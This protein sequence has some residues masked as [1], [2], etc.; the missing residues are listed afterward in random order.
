MAATFLS[1]NVSVQAIIA[2][3]ES[4][5]TAL[6][7]SRV[8]SPVPIFAMSPIESSRRKMA[9]YR[10][11]IPVAHVPEGSSMEPVIEKALKLLWDHDAIRD[12][13][14][15][16]L[17]MGESQGTEG[18]TNTMRLITIGEDSRPDNQAELDLR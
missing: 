7:L 12:G 8:Q 18:G 5:S 17:T 11:V 1:T 9:L 15:V 16:L 2:F 4:G 14:R 3:T 10:N 13:D 6:W